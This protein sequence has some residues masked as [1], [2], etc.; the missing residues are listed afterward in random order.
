[1]YYRIFDSSLG[2]DV[3]ITPNSRYNPDHILVL[4]DD[5]VYWRW[6]SSSDWEEV[7]Q[8]AFPGQL[9]R[10]DRGKTDSPSRSDSVQ[11]NERRAAH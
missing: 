7:E 9:E 6:G 10:I 8:I 2:E 1:V 4:S 5:N 11:R 3:P